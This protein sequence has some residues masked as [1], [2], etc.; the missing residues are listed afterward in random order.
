[1][2]SDLLILS[3]IL[4]AALLGFTTNW[5]RYDVVALLVLLAATFTGVVPAEQA[6][7]GFG[8]PAVITVAAVLVISCGFRQSG[9]VDALSSLVM[10][11]GKRPTLQVLTL[12]FS[13]AVLS[14][15]MN[16]VG[17]LALMLPVALKMA[18]THGLAASKLLMPLSFG[19]LL[20][21]LTTL[22]GT[23]PNVIIASM[24]GHA[25]RP[26]FGFFDFAR[27]GGG[28]A[29]AGIAYITLIGWR[30]LPLRK[31]QTSPEERF[32]V[33]SY[34]GELRVTEK[35]KTVGMTLRDLS[36]AVEEAPSVLAVLREDQRFAA[37]RFGGV[38][39]EGDVL[40]VEGETNE[41]EALAHRAG[42]EIGLNNTDE[43]AEEVEVEDETD[44]TLASSSSEGAHQ[45][46]TRDDEAESLEGKESTEADQD[47]ATPKK[48]ER[49]KPADLELSE[50]VVLAQSRLVGRTVGEARLQSVHDLVLIAVSRQGRR[51]RGRL[52]DVR[53]EDGDVL[54]LQGA[55]S[56][57]S[58]QMN[59][60]GCLP[61]ADRG[62]RLGKPRKLLLS[63]AI[64]ITVVVGISLGWTT[65]AVGMMAGAATMVVSGVVSLRRAYEG[66]D[67]PVLV[68]LACMIP[69]GKAFETT[70]GAAWLANQLLVWGSDWTPT[71]SLAVLL[72]ISMCLS[73]LIN[74]AA[75]AVLLAPIAI[76]LADGLDANPQAFLMAVAIGASCAFL[77]P[78][79]HQSNTLV[80]GPGGYRFG[81]YWKLGLPLQIVVAIV[82]M[83]LLLWVWPL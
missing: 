32:Q 48:R 18:R 14:S 19:S 44:T 39:R 62:L 28:V 77:T 23:P 10:R 83:P 6:F 17:A 76:N 50:V 15:F 49:P 80:M 36:E 68:L 51:M 12:T 26:P 57:L 5:L 20:G 38:L 66:V 53:F 2:S 4:A 37:Y 69:V 34:M 81:D 8:H 43:T 71:V 52:R 45:Q 79:G 9:V 64:F 31:G 60:L 27:V 73:D 55:E 1:M 82:A 70:G 7:S 29:I 74:N 11:V 42:L 78:I 58:E 22:I 33:A 13:V 65:A 56:E 30:F 46:S 40:V 67:W 63:A 59:E 3:V 41:I 21:G 61:L 54:L 24:S 47:D 25:D 16:N 75:A 35:S 72:L